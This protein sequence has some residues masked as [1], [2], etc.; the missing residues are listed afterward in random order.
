M[1]RWPESVSRESTHAAHRGEEG[2]L[3]LLKRN[4]QF[5]AQAD[6]QVNVNLNKHGRRDLPICHNKGCNKPLGV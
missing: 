1:S 3:G 2:V 4:I 6:F 5:D